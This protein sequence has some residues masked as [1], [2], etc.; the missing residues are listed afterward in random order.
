MKNP[1]PNARAS[2]AETRPAWKIS[3]TASRSPVASPPVPVQPCRIFKMHIDQP[4]IVLEHA[5]LERPG[6]LQ[7]PH[8]RRQAHRRNRALGQHQDHRIADANTQ[9]CS[10]RGADQRSVGARLQVSQAA[11]AKQ[12]REHR[13]VRLKCRID[14]AHLNARKPSL[15]HSAVLALQRTVPHRSRPDWRERTRACSANP[16]AVFRHR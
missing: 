6:D 12:R 13:D 15:R 7:A 8:A 9:F 4:A 16:P 3:V 2:C 1:P 11:V 5:G 10:Q 14:T